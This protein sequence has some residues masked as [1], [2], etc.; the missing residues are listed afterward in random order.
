MTMDRG[1]PTNLG[2]DQKS[3]RVPALNDSLQTDIVRLIP[4]IIDAA[5]PYSSAWRNPWSVITPTS[6]HRK[7][8]IKF[9]L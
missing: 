3:D 4:P 9:I 5:E 2:S 1:N 8:R 7:A 6:P